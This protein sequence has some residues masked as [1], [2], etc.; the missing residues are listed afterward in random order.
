M[1]QV[2]LNEHRPPIS[3][4]MGNTRVKSLL[5]YYNEEPICVIQLQDTWHFQQVNIAHCFKDVY[6]KRFL[7]APLTLKEDDT[8][9]FEILEVYPGLKYTDVAISEF[10]YEGA[11]N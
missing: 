8:F 4:R 1:I 5:F 3:F 9:K 6:R 7:E 2:L 10:I 11:K